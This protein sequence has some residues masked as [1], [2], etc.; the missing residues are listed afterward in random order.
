MPDTAMVIVLILISITVYFIIFDKKQ[1]NMAPL[2][3]GTYKPNIPYGKCNMG[4]FSR[5]DCMVGN[6][7][8]ESTIT[9][10]EY[11]NIQCAQDPD[12][13][14]RE[15]CRRECMELMNGGCR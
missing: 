7:H 3:F 13:S 6:C 5:S 15:K 9:N 14:T 4:N 2:D 12:Q 8:L 1:E 10:D 11:C